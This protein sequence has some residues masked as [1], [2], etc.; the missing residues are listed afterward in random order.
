METVSRALKLL[1][2]IATR[3]MRVQEVA[4]SLNIHK[5]SA[6]RLLSVLQ[7]DN[8]VRL[9]QEKKYE[10]G[11]AV[12][13]L[14]Y[15]LKEN[16]D[17][18][19]VARPYLE[20]ISATTN[21]TVHLAIL[22]GGEVVYI[23]KIDANRL[24]RMYSRTGRRA[25]S[26]CTG[27]GKAILAYLPAKQLDRVLNTMEFKKY[28]ENTIITKEALQAELV[29]IRKNSLAWDREEHEEDIYCIAAPIFD[30]SNRVIASISISITVKYASVEK[31]AS[32]EAD[33]KESAENISREMGHVALKKSS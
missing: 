13:E 16:L 4:A 33:L 23:D 6:S 3:P 15:I 7:E 29:E 9:N 11:Y 12:F 14:A 31:L 20:T 28:T 32:Y 2:V 24:I 27:V 25:S 18:R 17:L 22:D 10:L 26:Y 8:F 5:S 30:F 21:E 1:K 19:V